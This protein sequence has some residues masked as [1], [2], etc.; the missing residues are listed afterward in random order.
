MTYFKLKSA[1][2]AAVIAVSTSAIPAT[3]N[4]HTVSLGFVPAENAGE[5]TFWVGNYTHMGRPGNVPLE[6]SLKLSGAVG[7][8]Y[9]TSVTEF[10][11]SQWN[12]NGG[13]PLGLVD[14][15]NN[16]YASG[17]AHRNGSLVGNFSDSYIQACLACGPVT[18]WQGVTVSGLIAGSY[19]FEY[20]KQANP[21]MDW[22]PWNQSLSNVFTLKDVDLQG[23]GPLNVS[24]VPLPAAFPLYGAGVAIMGFLGW[25]RKR[26]QSLE[27][28]KLTAAA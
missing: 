22:T 28:K 27:Q 9:T 19:I 5:V 26:K 24:A 18:G 3:A 20:V 21:T 17:R 12:G 6:G 11:L 1:A 10:D 4:A 25:N 7:T 16:F 8:D 15:V 13:K 23:G 14:G 2:L